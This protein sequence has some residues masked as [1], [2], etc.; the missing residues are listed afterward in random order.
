MEIISSKILQLS[1]IIY[2]ASIQVDEEGTEAAVATM[3]MIGI[4]SIDPMPGTRFKQIAIIFPYSRYLQ[5]CS[6]I[7]WCNSED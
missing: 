1:Q 2:V 4:T 6:F 7:Q 3:G 5:Q